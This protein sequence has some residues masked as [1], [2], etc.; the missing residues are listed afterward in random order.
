MPI[1]VVFCDMDGT[2]LARDKRVPPEN[3]ALL[4]RLADKGIPFVPCSGRIWRGLP[5]EVLAHPATRFAIGS[6][7][8]VVMALHEGPADEP[9]TTPATTPA[10]RRLH[11]APMG[12]DRTL[13]LYERV[14]HLPLTFDVLWDGHV[15]SE[16]RRFE[17]LA[18]F[19]IELHDLHTIMR[20]RTPVDCDVPTLLERIDDVERI[21]MIWGDDETGRA[22]RAAAAAD[23]TLHST[24][25][26]PTNVEVMDA[27]TSKGAAARW[28]CD[29]LGVSC[30]DAI[31]FG[32]SPND[33][34]MAGAVGT[35]VAMA[36]ATDD[37]KAA[38]TCVSAHDNDHAGVARHL[39]PLV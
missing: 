35:L 37:L 14:R 6:D 33:L 16:R 27:A 22:A 32:D 9:S 26:G 7:G 28:L 31:A 20:L 24:S 1:R 23:P 4:D 2:F 8:A 18:G 29:H 38:A 19:P 21:T 15:Y 17:M 13:A 30:D 10:A 39:V 3:H 34:S 12:R 25:S 11:L 36:N 5:A